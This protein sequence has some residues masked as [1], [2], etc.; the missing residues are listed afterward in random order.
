MYSNVFNYLTWFIV[1]YVLFK[2]FKKAIIWLYFLECMIYFR[3]LSFWYFD[4][5]SKSISVNYCYA[6][7]YNWCDVIS[8]GNCGDVNNSGFNIT[9]MMTSS[10]GNISALLALCVGNSPVTGEFPSQRPLTRSFDISLSCALNKRLSKQSRC[11]WFE[12]RS[13]SIWRHC[14]VTDRSLQTHK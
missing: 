1:C 7:C 2:C 13:C 6:S 9:F 10:N 8:V 12:T 4:G 14:D 11:W 3:S 5:T